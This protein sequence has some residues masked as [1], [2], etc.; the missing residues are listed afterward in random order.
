M[1]TFSKIE[2]LLKN[3]T[4]HFTD[5]LSAC[6]P[7]FDESQVV[8]FSTD[9]AKQDIKADKDYINDSYKKLLDAIKNLYISALEKR[10]KVS[11]K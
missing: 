4:F 10:I 5:K 7:N 2:K 1:E 3:D 8:F 11:Y 9:R 6:W